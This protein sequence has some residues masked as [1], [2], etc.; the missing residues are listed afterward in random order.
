MMMLCGGGK[1]KVHP[2]LGRRRRRP[3]F[4][5]ARGHSTSEPRPLA[6][7]SPA[8]FEQDASGGR[9]A[10]FANRWEKGDTAALPTCL[11]FGARGPSQLRRRHEWLQRRRLAASQPRLEYARAQQHAFAG[12][13]L[14][15]I[16]QRR[17]GRGEGGQVRPRSRVTIHHHH[18][19]PCGV[20][21]QRRLLTATHAD[22]IVRTKYEPTSTTTSSSSTA[23][24]RERR[25]CSAKCVTD[26][27]KAANAV[28]SN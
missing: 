21:N 18:T 12:P 13:C 19:P 4:G 6:K 14:F 24:R 10:K 23:G 7:C 3:P 11:P 16:R 5:L 20:A 8:R 15:E 27:M 22:D 9:V 2:P 28:Q 1:G 17:R 25:Q 26:Q